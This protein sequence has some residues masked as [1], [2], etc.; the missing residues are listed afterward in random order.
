MGRREEALTAYDEALAIRRD[1]AEREPR[2]FVEWLANT[3]F[4]KAELLGAAEDEFAHLVQEAEAAAQRT[5][6]ALVAGEI[7]T[8]ASALRHDASLQQA[9]ETKQ[10]LE[11]TFAQFLRQRRQPSPCRSMT[12]LPPSG[13]CNASASGRPTLPSR[14]SAT[15][16]MTPTV[17]ASSCSGKTGACALTPASTSGG[18]SGEPAGP[19]ATSTPSSALTITLTTPATCSPC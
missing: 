16:T 8:R 11:D 2:A 3:L 14:C 13:S 18:C 10:Q 5:P 4:N 9:W 1:L 17:A 6:D 12:A 15:Q 19:P 7:Q